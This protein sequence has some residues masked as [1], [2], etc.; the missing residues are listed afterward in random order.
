MYTLFGFQV[1]HDWRQTENPSVVLRAKAGAKRW[2]S[3]E[4]KDLHESIIAEMSLELRANLDA[5]TPFQERL[6]KDKTAPSIMKK[7]RAR[8]DGVDMPK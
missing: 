1:Y 4:A 8:Y 5:M 7:F 2:N 6:S 3:P